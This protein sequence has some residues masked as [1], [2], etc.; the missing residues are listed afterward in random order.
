MS[1]RCVSKP[2]TALPL[3]LLMSSPASAL[4]NTVGFDF[5]SDNQIVGITTRS[6][7]ARSRPTRSRP[8][9]NRT[10]SWQ[11][12]DSTQPQTGT[13]NWMLAAFGQAEGFSV[14]TR[15][16]YRKRQISDTGREATPSRTRR[17]AY[18]TRKNKRVRVAALGLT[19]TGRSF[20]KPRLVLRGRAKISC[21]P[22]GL[23]GILRN[24]ERRFGRRIHVISGY[25]SH[26]HNRRVGGARRSYH[27]KCMAADIAVPKVN[28]YVLARYLKKIP[29]RGGVGTYACSGFVHIDIGP[30]RAWHWRCG[31]KKYRKIARRRVQRRRLR[32]ARK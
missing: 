29:G 13:P 28:K 2:L 30:R 7:L 23:N 8:A 16:K 5:M 25:R 27:L 1:I 31:R 4:P 26:R 19:T 10:E 3:V 9:R 18:R 32:L 6:L 12:P 21:F 11:S 24:V 22:R 15:Q 17:K 20:A 14:H